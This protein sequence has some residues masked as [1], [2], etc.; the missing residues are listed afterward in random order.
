[1]S[2]IGEQLD[3][4]FKAVESEIKRVD[5]S[6]EQKDSALHGLTEAV[7]ALYGVVSGTLS[8]LDE[9]SVRVEKL[10]KIPPVVLPSEPTEPKQEPDKEPDATLKI[11]SSY[12]I[13]VSSKSLRTAGEYVAALIRFPNM[14]VRLDNLRLRHDQKS[15]SADLEVTG[16]HIDGSIEWLRCVFLLEKNIDVNTP[17]IYF[18]D[19]MKEPQLRILSNKWVETALIGLSGLSYLVK[20]PKHNRQGAIT[21]VFTKEYVGNL[22]ARLRLEQPIGD[23][24]HLNLLFTLHKDIG[25]TCEAA[26]RWHG[27]LNGNN[28]T[29]PD[30]ISPNAIFLDTFALFYDLSEPITEHSYL[31]DTI[32]Y[33]ALSN[34]S[35][36]EQMLRPS[37]VDASGARV[38]PLSRIL[39]GNGVSSAAVPPEITGGLL[40]LVGPDLTIGLARMYQMEPCALAVESDKRVAIYI[41]SDKFWISY[42]SGIYGVFGIFT[43]ENNPQA[44]SLLNNPLIGFGDQATYGLAEPEALPDNITTNYLASLTSIAYST[45]AKRKQEGLQGLTTF[46]LYPRSWGEWGP[47]TGEI[48]NLKT[49][50]GAYMDATFTDYWCTTRVAFDLAA[51]TG[52]FS[53]IHEITFPAARRQLH[54]QMFHGDVADRNDYIGSLP[55][56]YGMYRKDM[57]SSHQYLENMFIYYY[58]TGNK[59]VVQKLE[60]AAEVQYKRFARGEASASGRHAN[61]WLRVFRFLGSALSDLWIERFIEVMRKGILSHYLQGEYKGN[62]EA[63]WTEIPIVMLS[64]AVQRTNTMYSWGYYDSDNLYALAQLTNNEAVGGNTP[65]DIIAKTAKTAATLGFSLVGGDP[66]NVESKWARVLEAKHDGVKFLSITGGLA[67]NEDLLFPDDKPAMAAWFARA[68]EIDPSLT[69]IADGLISLAFKRITAKPQPMGKLMGLNSAKLGDALRARYG[70]EEK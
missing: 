50:D 29:A 1:M 33:E 9:L 41:A 56:G 30:K 36:M 18:L 31:A 58:L 15:I 8:S 48:G 42:R 57:N 28:A 20:G 65:L 11:L 47:G 17:G 14:G 67:G 24:L 45:L 35:R 6:L 54:S 59:E 53:L 39:V 7:K 3:E 21:S 46:G 68:A 44:W 63:I 10:E 60:R 51:I 5:D 16:N 22:T 70:R 34:D 64:S 26:L 62:I 19:Q 2:S 25:F 13:T 32:E 49:W 66:K 52:D 55:A 4:R 12:R 43:G 69:P 23:D 61:Q 40:N 27:S 37:R 38:N